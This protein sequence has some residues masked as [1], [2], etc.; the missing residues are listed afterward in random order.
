MQTVQNKS[1]LAIAFVGLATTFFTAYFLWFSSQPSTINSWLL[2]VLLVAVFSIL[3]ILEFRKSRGQE[4]YKLA[5]EER[6]AKEAQRMETMTRFVESIASG[7]YNETIEFEK[8]DHLAQM[9]VEMKNKLML[10]AETDRKRNWATQGMAEIGTILRDTANLEELY[11]NVTKFV[12]KYTKSNQA[13]L[14]VL[15]DEKQTDNYLELVSTYAYDR[16]KYLQK[17]IELGEGLA[18]QAVLEGETIYMTKVPDQ[19]VTITS[20]L[21]E[22]PPSAL[23]I[24]PLK[25]NDKTY[26][27]IEIAS[28][29]PYEQFEIEF[30]EKLAESIASSISAARINDRTKV[31]LQQ[32]QQQ[33]EE[34][35]AQ[36]E[37]VRQNMEELTATQEEMSRKDAEMSGQLNAINNTMATIEFSMDGYI[38]NANDKFLDVMG[39]SADEVKGKHHRMFADQEYAESEEYKKFWLNLKRGIPQTGEFQRIGKRGKNVWL[40]ASYTPILNKDG[41]PFK[42][43]KFAQDMTEVKIKSLD[44]EGQ[45][46]AVN[47]TMATIE[48]SLDGTILTANKKFL[49]AMGYSLEEIK[50]K[51]H[52]IFAD[53]D[54]ANSKEYAQ[55]WTDLGKG[56]SQAGEFRR[57][58]KNKK[59]VWLSA[60]YT[61][62]ADTS[63]KPYKVVKFA[64]DVTEIKLKTLDFEGQVSAIRKTNAVIEFDTTGKI[65]YANEIFVKAMGYKKQ[66]EFV[67]Q[68]HRI[69][70]LAEEQQS[71]EY[72]KF[73]ERLSK[74][75]SFTG[76]FKRKK[77]DGSEVWLQ[78]SYNPILDTSGKAYKAIKFAQVIDKK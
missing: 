3:A 42:V 58:G 20:G 56:K 39:Y 8:G 40:S 73:W 21:G 67:G 5:S 29:Q 37:E 43:I 24:I 45:I 60:S 68:H 75:E 59:E 15:N 65:L 6:F 74:G 1:T 48:F 13:S 22:A 33:T 76:E 47:Y 64:Q 36:E 30:L 52:R 14:F 31:L 41:V 17:K 23:I 34:L 63:G 72:K 26:G 7:T 46:N 50:G 10:S 62:I 19:Y 53:A 61:P 71:P 70:V 57:F 55:F 18:G 28:F 32:S 69:F 11:T 16:K 38:N 9:M 44:F 78:A 51:H 35:R 12:V 2:V 54:F 77:L 27:V 25:L 4:K 66:E 49:E